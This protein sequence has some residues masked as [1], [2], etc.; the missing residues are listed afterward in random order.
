MR[1]IILLF[2][3]S[4]LFFISCGSTSA[5]QIEEGEIIKIKE[6]GKLIEKR[7][8]DSLSKLAIIINYDTLNQQPMDSVIFF[9]GENNMLDS[10]SVYNYNVKNR[11][12]VLDKQPFVSTLY[13]NRYSKNDC[14][15]IELIL[16]RQFLEEVLW[17]ICYI[18]AA[19]SDDRRIKTVQ[20]EVDEETVISIKE[21]NAVFRD[22]PLIIQDYFLNEK[23][24]DV[25]FH[26]LGGF[27]LRESYIFDNGTFE[28]S[29]LYNRDRLIETTILI[30]YTDS[31]G[32]NEEKIINTYEY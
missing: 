6:S 31:G 25:E 4:N 8:L 1:I 27:L 26:I 24:K 21:I 12:Y 3:I 10:V 7:Y 29:F 19:I 15:I 22:F 17:N 16:Q 9:Y 28:R 14:E 2:F 32:F 20:S 23:L 30:K 5:S 18:Q 11:H 13:K